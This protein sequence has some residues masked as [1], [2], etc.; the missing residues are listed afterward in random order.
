M[1]GLGM[2][3]FPKVTMFLL[4][5]FRQLFPP[6]C[7]L[8]R[9]TLSREETGVFCTECLSGFKPLTDA[10]CPVCALPFTGILN[11]SHLCGRCTVNLPAYEKV[12]AV[13]VYARSLRHAIHQFKFNCKI[14][15]DRPLGMLLDEVVDR[16]LNVELVVPVPLSSKRLRRRSYNQALLL[17]R[18]FARIRKLPV[19]TDLLL[20]ARDT[21]PQQRLSAKQRRQNLRGVFK[22]RGAVSGATVLLV[23]DVLTTGATAEACSQVLLAGGAK[24][25]YVAV[26]GRA[27]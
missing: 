24:A 11:S 23:D 19:A 15:L 18:E 8:C 21:E 26:I 20:K 2:G 7:P 25:V 9:H 6:A 16:D 14:G 12:Y 5:L 4:L 3:G 10:H 1:N 22:L 27:A 13:G 17:A